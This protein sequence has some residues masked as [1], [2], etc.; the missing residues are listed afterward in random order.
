MSTPS[1]PTPTTPGSVTPTLPASPD[2]VYRS[3]FEDAY[4]ALL[5][6]DEHGA[7]VDCNQMALHL[8]GTTRARLLAAG[9]MAFACSQPDAEAGAD[10]LRTDAE[11]RDA[12]LRTVRTGQP[13]AGGWHGRRA[14]DS[15][16]EAWLTLHGVQSPVGPRVQLTLRDALRNGLRPGPAPEEQL[17]LD[18]DRRELRDVLSRNDLAYV[19]SDRQGRV[20]DVNDFFLSLVGYERAEVIG[21]SYHDLFSAA[22]EREA[23][24]QHFLAAVRGEQELVFNERTVLTS[25]GQ[26]RLITWNAEFAHDLQGHVVGLSCVG[27]DLTDRQLV[28]RAL[29]DNRNRLQDFFDN[30]HDLIQ[31]LSVDNH[32]LFVNK[33]WKEKLGYTEEDLPTLT[34]NDVVHPYYKAKLLYQLRNLYKGEK[35]NK[36]E[37]V[38]LTKANKPVHLIGSISCSWQ[39]DEPVSTRAILHDITDR[40]KAERLQKVYYS[41][42]NLAISSKDLHSLYGAIHRELS[43]IIETN[44]FYI[45]L[46]DEDRAHLQFVYFVDQNAPGEQSLMARPFSSGVSEYIIRTG[47]PQFLLRAELEKLITDG[48]VTAFGSMPEVMLCSPL[49]I[50]ER[51]IGVIAV[52]DYH[53]AD[54]YAAGDIEILHFISNQV[55]LAIER[56][57]NEVQINKQNARLNA[58]FESGTHLM[59]SVDTHSRLTSF[60]R[61]YG[62]YFLRRN[63]VRP[64]LN[65]NLW[66]ADLNMMED[67]SR[68]AF[69]ENYQRAFQGQPQRFEVQLHDAQGNES[70]RE[71]YLNPIYLDDGTFEEISGIAHDITGKKNSQL[72]LAAQEEK[73]RAIFESLQDVYYR[74]NAEG[75][76]TLVSPSLRDAL[77]YSPEEAI[78]QNIID[79]Y[80]VPEDFARL[81]KTVREQG[82]LRNFETAIR[83]K[84]GHYVSMLINARAVDGQPGGTEG[85]AH[86]ITK[87][88]ETQDKLKHAKEEAESA[89]EAKTQFLANM[90][91]ELRTP[92]NGIIGMIDLLHQTVSSEEQEDYVDTLRKSSEALM[93]ILNDILDL[94]K[95]QAGKLQLNT[96]GLDLYYTLDKIH[97]LFANR[98]SQ[99]DLQFTYHVTPHTPRFIV[100][101]ETRLLQIL[102]NLTSNAIKFT[103]QG[104]VSIQVS[105][106]AT[107]GEA[108]T[109][110][111]A[112]KDSGI[113]ISESNAKLLFTN[114][115]QLDTTPTKSF[116]GTGLGLAI[117]KQL[118][119]LLGGD[120]GVDSDV[121]QG[122]TFW[123]TMRCQVAHNEAEIVQERVAA[124]ERPQ[125]I[126]RFDTVPRVLL[127]DDNPI[128]QKVATRLLDKLGCHVVVASDGFE[129]ISRADS[130]KTVYDL[131]FMDIQMPEMDG[132]TAMKE[133]RRR[134]GRHCPPVVAMTAYSMKEDAERFV[135]EGMDDYVSKPVKSQDLYTVLRR[136]TST[137]DRP[138]LAA[139]TT[140]RPGL[141]PTALPATTVLELPADVAVAE[142]DA[143]GCIDAEVVDQLCQLG[144]AEFAAS[145]YADFEQEAE[146][147]LAEAGALVAAGHYAGIL[148]HL[149]QLKGTG[150]TLG[151]NRL[152]ECAKRMEHDLKYEVT[153]ATTQDFQALLRYFAQFKT[154][155]PNATSAS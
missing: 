42:A 4:D 118:A 44:N 79:H 124:R 38:F 8:L 101:D 6:Y 114:F 25:T 15:C 92:M 130:T 145:L 39:D 50:G 99:K 2:S 16:F 72:E 18:W 127:V 97:S 21:K 100:T 49:S 57:H 133:I 107:D 1:T 75:Q 109:L 103:A 22:T 53:K 123:F 37:T 135:Q 63:G 140:D 52:Q 85:T 77:G 33:A 76:V 120:I 71:I 31:N 27:R 144:G 141:T 110:R 91:H 26:P 82:V 98:A 62:A 29:S 139:R 104:T 78:G 108:H 96:H 83:H 95:I 43:K 117:S 111:F 129:A 65:I 74:T 64:T 13:G 113:G 147:L 3:L 105:S 54:A 134:L 106:I 40:I 30:A 70:W 148:P 112:V 59:W 10:Y 51:I 5:L 56:K 19:F 90:S 66:H 41:I 36:L 69:T 55:A 46:C 48:D 12:V 152:A 20:V 155:Y 34:L 84:H 142:E 116:G 24:R 150:F 86:D 73:F 137:T 67:N 9:L 68:A 14:D 121:N 128:N 126:V 125:E 143:A 87:L 93:A 154:V 28:A 80:A 47:R 136:W 32:F 23:N 122:S 17:L 45:A 149:H 88:K 11:L 115:T 58:I 61:N 119:E 153:T 132:V 60:N 131:I 151:I 35:V 146:Q 94:S 138:V 89:L 7:L 102:S 81:Q